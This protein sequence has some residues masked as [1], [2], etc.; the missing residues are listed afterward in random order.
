MPKHYGN[1][2]IPQKP[3]PAPSKAFPVNK[4]GPPPTPKATPH[5]PTRENIFRN[6]PAR[7][8]NSPGSRK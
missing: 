8:I 1:D 2:P 4:E 6:A 3:A 7:G 5:R